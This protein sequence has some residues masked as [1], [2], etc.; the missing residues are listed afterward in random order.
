MN[1][2]ATLSFVP[3]ASSRAGNR[4]MSPNARLAGAALFVVLGSMARIGAAQYQQ[5]FPPQYPT[6]YQGYGLYDHASTLEEGLAN[7][8]A[9][10]THAAGASNLLH[11][12]AARNYEEAF[13]RELDNRLKR[14]QTYH[15]VRRLH[16]EYR[17]AERAPRP[18]AEQMARLAKERVPERLSVKEL[19]PLTGR[20]EW[21]AVLEDNAFKAHRE[22]LD[23][24]VSKWVRFNGEI[25][26]DEYLALQRS[27]KAMQAEL[28]Q[29]VK[30]YPTADYIQAKK[31]LEGL[32]YQVARPEAAIN[33]SET[34]PAPSAAADE[35]LAEARNG[36]L[37]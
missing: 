13:S 32:A 30:Q 10:L 23:E 25:G 37:R 20:L 31:L 26:S 9:N 19:D 18:T 24:L 22:R 6:G 12:Q 34:P 7:G 28:K 8:A 3:V 5:G 21:P 33:K 27:A 14:T 15:E 17:A 35:K 11:S 36:S 29:R 16:G 4:S 2:A 1:A